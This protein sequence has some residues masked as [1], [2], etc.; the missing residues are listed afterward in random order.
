MFLKAPWLPSPFHPL[1]SVQ[2]ENMAHALWDQ[3]PSLNMLHRSAVPFISLKIKLFCSFLWLRKIPLCVHA[4]FPLS[5]HPLVDHS[6]IFIT[7]LVWTVQCL[8]GNL[9]D[10]LGVHAQAWH[11]QVIWYSWRKFHANIYSGYQFTFPPIVNK[12]FPSAAL[13][14][15]FGRV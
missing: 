6:L 2:T 4:T 10:S 13:L 3:F 12:S 7:L 14:L 1:Q 9:T 8:H 15:I 5:I 11:A